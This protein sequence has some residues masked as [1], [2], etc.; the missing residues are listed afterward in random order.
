MKIRNLTLLLLSVFIASAQAD[1]SENF[2][3]DLNNNMGTVL[4]I[5]TG[6]VDLPFVNA[7]GTGSGAADSLLLTSIPA[8]F[9]TLAGGNDVTSWADQV[10][11]TFMVTGGAITSFEFLAVTSGNNSVGDY[12]CINSTGGSAG[13]IGGW[14]CPGDLNELSET[15]ATFGFNF[16]GASGVTFTPSSATPEPSFLIPTLTMVLFLTV[17]VARKTNRSGQGLD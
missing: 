12:F 15:A 11:N 7:G 9:G 10:T 3:V 16:G 13:L 8:G 17:F 2:S 6:T 4:G 5:V 14:G 1:I